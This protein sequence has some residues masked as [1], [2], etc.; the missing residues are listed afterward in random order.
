MD[1]TCTLDGGAMRCT[2]TSYTALNAPVFCCSGMQPMACVSGGEVVMTLGSQIE[3]AIPDLAPG[4]P[5]EV[6]L[7]YDAEK[8]QPVN[9]AWL[10]LGPY[11]RHAGGTIPLPP[12]PAGVDPVTWP[13]AAPVEGLRLL[14]APTSWTPGNGTL[15]VTGFSSSHPAFGAVT[16]LAERTGLGPFAGDAPVAVTEADLPADAYTLTI[17]ADGPIG[18]AVS[19]YGGAFYGAITLLH[20]R[21]L[22]DGALP[23]GTI[24]DTPR[25][26]WR[27][28]HLDC[29]RHFFQPDTIHRLLD[30]MA[31]LKLNRFHW[32]FADDE[33]FRLQVASCPELWQKTEFQGEGE[34]IPALFGEGP[35]KGGS[36]SPADV[37]ALL[38]HAKALNI[39]VMPEIEVPAHALAFARVYPGTR[40]PEDTGQERSVQGYARNVLN[41][42]M[43]ET[44]ERLIPLAAEVAAMFP[45]GHLHLGGDELPRDT[46]MGSPAARALMAQEGLETTQDLMGWTMAKLAAT[47]P[48]T[49]VAAWEEAAGGSQG[50]IGHNAL[51][52]SWT[53]QGPGL[54][55][56]RAG[57]DV[58]M[59]PA[60][61]VYLDMAH[62][63]D[64]QDWGAAWA[65]FVSLPDTIAWDPVPDEIADIP[66]RI[67]GVQ[68]CFWG[69]FTTQDSQMWPML[70]PRMLGVATKAWEPR[71]KSTAHSLTAL[72][73]HYEPLL[74]RFVS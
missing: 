6:V 59:T 74:G 37:E 2:I 62:S 60:Q 28:Q 47:L 44:W 11:L 72:A 15:P 33:A 8:Y 45:F 17:P 63:S 21:H 5:H 19:G 51:L 58:V 73:G 56:A 42:A 20:L 50:G 3:V 65:A 35:R 66:E 70:L 22:Y 71:G 53:G 32:H 41:P 30:L 55:A 67:A 4:V 7:R 36:Y 14:P 23:V 40:D 46:W 1:F 16:A 24:Q 12:L 26:G 10:P 34:L 54:A 49:R 27:G 69:E 38:A 25:F 68:G 52:F 39:E 31:L 61:H 29:A 18:L 9:R 43:P 64:P 48:G 57:Y 13:A